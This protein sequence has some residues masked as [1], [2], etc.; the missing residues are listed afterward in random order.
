[1]VSVLP[2]IEPLRASRATPS[3]HHDLLAAQVVAAVG[4]PGRV[5]RVGDQRGP[6]RSGGARRERQ[7]AGVQV[8]AVGDQFAHDRPGA[9]QRDHRTGL[10]VVRRPHAV[11][12]V[13]A[14]GRAG[15]DPASVCS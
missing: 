14:D 2:A 4:H 12:Q 13:G 8:D 11:E 15:R 1:M 10:A 5:H 9:E 7:H 3:G 6:V